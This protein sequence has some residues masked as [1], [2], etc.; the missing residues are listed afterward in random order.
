MLYTGENLKEISFPIGGIGTG[1]IGLAGNGRLIDWEI[2]NRPSKGSENGYTHIAIKAETKEKK[3]VKVLNGDLLKDYIGQ[4]KLS[5]YT[6][7]GFGPD[8]STM[9]GLPHFSNVIFRGEFPIAELTFTDAGFPGIVTLRAF[10][11]LIPL[12]DANSSLPAAF[13]ELGITNN[14]KEEV[15]YTIAFSLQNPFEVSMNKITEDKDYAIV[16]LVNAGVEADNIDYGDLTLATDSKNSKI[17]PYWYRGR[18]QD[19]IVTFWNEFSEMDE[20]DERIYDTYGKNDTC[21]LSIK[22]SALPGKIEH[23]RFLLAWNVPNNHNYWSG[24]ALP[25]WKNYYATV[26]ENSLET[27]RYCLENWDYLYEKTLV[28]KNELFNSTLDE[29]VIDAVS[30]TLSVLKSPTV[31][32]LEDGSF[33]G[34]EGVH[35]KEGSCEGTCQHV[36]NYAYALCFLF[37]KLE[38][39]IRNLEFRYGLGPSG[40]TAFRL[41]LPLDC[42]ISKERRSLDGQIN[43]CVDG[44]MGCVIKSYREWKISGDDTWLRERWGDIIKILDYAWHPENEDEWDR[45]KD[46]V[47][48]GRQHHTLDMELFGPSAWLEGMYL[49]ALKAASEM[50]LYLGDMDKHKEYLEL[51]EKGFAWTKD[52][53]F[54]GSYFVQK[55]DIFDRSIADYFGVADCYWN[56]ERKQLKYQIAGGSILDQMLGQWHASITGLGDIFDISQRKTALK[57]MFQ[58]HYKDSLRDFVNPWR[59]FAFNDEAACIICDYPKGAEKPVIPIPY[60]EEAMTGFEYAFAGLLISEGYVEEGIKVVRAIRNRYD[61]RKRNPWNE[62]ECGSNYARAMASFALLPIFS[63]FEYHVPKGY[64]GF[65][66]VVHTDFSTIWSLGTGWGVFEKTETDLRIKLN[67]GF[68]EISSVGVKFASSVKEIMIDGNVCEFT[69]REG[70]ISFP[71]KVV[72]QE[73]YITF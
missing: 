47:L 69:F 3:V 62:I 70:I 28:F 54:N 40:K 19:R 61:G 25:Q 11:P 31:L 49:A 60:G 63:G 52:N 22:K 5:R 21:T 57:N 18:W 55:I 13:F 48:E 39:S 20:L 71:K 9:C 67:S 12:D 33:Y 14:T 38:Q 26:F 17:Q 36:W 44:Q 37:P 15:G 65:S 6:G 73:I 72:R 23:A 64:I 59:T 51:F 58:N 16:Q 46:G 8:S 32:R 2:F 10:N 68:I 42:E 24:E 43:A 45:D 56:E 4:Y 53:L 1:C 30:S 66:P 7:Y 50:A 41:M 35:E 27:A 29:A 34:W